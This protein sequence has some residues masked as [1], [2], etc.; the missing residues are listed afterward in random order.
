[1]TV[2]QRG[3]LQQFRHAAA[4]AD[5][6][7][8]DVAAF[9]F[10]Q[11][12]KAPA[13]GLVLAGGDQ[14]P[15]WRVTLQIGIAPVVVGRQSFFDPLEPVIL[16]TLRQPDRVVEIEAHPAV[17]HE[18]E[19]GAD[20]AAHV[21]EHR[22]V[23]GK[24]FFAFRRT[25]M[26]RQLAADETELLRD[27]RAR[28][29]CVEHELVPDRTAEHLIHRLTTELAEQVPQG[30]VD[31]GDRIHHQALAAVVLCR[32]VHLVPDFFDLRRIPTF[33]KASEMLFDNE[34]SGLATR[35]DREPDRAVRGLDLDHE[36]AKYID[37]EATAALPVLRVAAH[38]SRDVIVDPVC[39][40]LVVVVGA[41][42]ANYAGTNLLDDWERHGL[43]PGETLR[44]SLRAKHR[45]PHT[46][47]GT[48]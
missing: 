16:R 2:R 28:T 34:R 14:H 25:V 33:Q 35:R 42:T 13:G 12:A 47:T 9:H 11:H 41:A 19:I 6:G 36:G 37:A 39:S 5:V 1:M 31:A 43:F 46:N 44:H 20:L 8:D 7:L 22:K 45:V 27:V 48:I 26:Q 4:P 15:A 3:N 32:K 24:A 30:E 10:E 18:P 29:G 17:E 23:L 38:G 40:L 21:R